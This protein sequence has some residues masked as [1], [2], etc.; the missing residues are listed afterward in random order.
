MEM[1]A[2]IVPGVVACKFSINAIAILELIEL[3]QGNFKE[4]CQTAVR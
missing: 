4:V 1:V 3:D 2:L